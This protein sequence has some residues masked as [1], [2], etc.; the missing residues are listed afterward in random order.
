MA[1]KMRKVIRVSWFMAWANC[2]M[3]DQWTLSSEQCHILTIMVHRKC[4]YNCFVCNEIQK[5]HLNNNVKVVIQTGK[6]L[7]SQLSWH[8]LILNLFTA[9]RTEMGLEKVCLCNIRIWW[10]YWKCVFVLSRREAKANRYHF[11]SS[12]LRSSYRFCSCFYIARRRCEPSYNTVDYACV[13]KETAR[14]T[15]Q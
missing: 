15:V 4:K 1:S 12:S 11:F 10:W 6:A 7:N 3:N 8:D 14:I 9:V 5:T 2:I 13:G